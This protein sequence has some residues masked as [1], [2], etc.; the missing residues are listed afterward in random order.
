MTKTISSQHHIDDEIVSAK[1]AARDYTVTISPDFVVEGVQVRVVLDGHHSL[2]AAR[3]DGV[4]PEYVVA[5]PRSDDRI[6]LLEAGKIEDFLSTA[7]MDGDYYDV[8]TRN[9]VW[10]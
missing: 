4:E 1:Q 5:T 2:A 8:E 6:G 7:Y 10:G 3:L 9:A